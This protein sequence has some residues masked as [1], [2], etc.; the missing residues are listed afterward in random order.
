MDRVR[1]KSYGAIGQGDRKKTEKE[2]TGGGE[3]YERGGEKQEGR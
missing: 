1:G 3:L 2:E